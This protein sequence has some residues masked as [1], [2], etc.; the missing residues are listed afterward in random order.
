VLGAG[1]AALVAGGVL[2]AVNENPTTVGKQSQFYD[3]TM[4]YGIGYTIG[5]VAA[6]GVGVYLWLHQ[7][8][9][10]TAPTVSMTPGGG[11][12]GWAGTF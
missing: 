8:K 4:P 5:G 1:A 3:H 10:R 11:T 6:V 9:A 2:I 12:V 7:S